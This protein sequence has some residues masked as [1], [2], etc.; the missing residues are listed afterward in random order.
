M[1]Q[2]FLHDIPSA[3][4][5]LLEAVL[6]FYLIR[7]KLVRLYPAFFL[8]IVT[9]ILQSCLW[10]AAAWYWYP[11]QLQAWTIYW[12]SQAVVIFTRWLAITEIARH[13]LADYSGIRRMATRILIVVGTCVLLYALLV[14][15]Y[16]WTLMVLN[17]DRAVELCIAT[18]VVGM[19]L[20]ARYYRLPMLDLERQ[21]AIGFCLYSCAWV[22][23]DSILEHWHGT[24]WDFLNYVNIL[25]FLASLLLWIGAVRGAQQPRNLPVSERLSPESYGE[26][27]AKLNSRL[28]LLNNRLDHMFRSGD[29][30]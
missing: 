30:R 1:P 19:F 10:H 15:R 14:S 21:L 22:I 6:L 23:N 13:V 25:A 9:V 8:Y 2:P 17:A 3:L 26:L 20:F 29:S 28:L 16:I 7:R 18:L 27:S 11:L 4:A 24:H 12:S 5:A